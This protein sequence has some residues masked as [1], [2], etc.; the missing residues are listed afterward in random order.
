[1]VSFGFLAVANN[2]LALRFKNG[3]A[4]NQTSNAKPSDLGKLFY[5][6]GNIP[7]GYTDLRPYEPK[8]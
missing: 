4:L 6:P 3:T 7:E 1:M 2:D 5:G 8:P